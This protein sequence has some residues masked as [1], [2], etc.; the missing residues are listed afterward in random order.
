MSCLKTLTLH[1][2]HTDW[3]IPL[4]PLFRVNKVVIVLL[5]YPFQSDALL[6]IAVFTLEDEQIVCR[7]SLSRWVNRQ[8]NSD[9]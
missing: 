2:T 3:S 6:A 4:S 7:L 9:N 5:H 1:C 8:T